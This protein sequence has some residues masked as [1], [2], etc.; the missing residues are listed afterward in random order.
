[1]KRE[2]H[3]SKSSLSW[4]ISW[5]LRLVRDACLTFAYESRRRFGRCFGRRSLYTPGRTVANPFIDASNGV[6]KHDKSVALRNVFAQAEFEKHL[7]NFEPNK[8]TVL[9]VTHE[10]SR[11]ESAI[12]V[13]RIGAALRQQY[14]LIVLTLQGGTLRNEIIAAGHLVLGPLSEEQRSPGFLTQLVA[15]I[16]RRTPVKFAIVNSIQSSIALSALWES[17][18][19]NV[20]LIHELAGETR[21][22]GQFRISALFSGERIFPSK[23]VRDAATA[24]TPDETSKPGLILPHNICVPHGNVVSATADVTERKQ[25]HSKPASFPQDELCFKSFI[26]R[27]DTVT[28]QCASKKEQEKVDRLVISKSN[29]FDVDFFRSPLGEVKQDDPVKSYVSAFSSGIKPRKATPGFHPA[30]Y[31]EHNDVDGRDPLAHYIDSGRPSGPWNFEVIRPGQTSHASNSLKVGLH[32]H[33]YYDEMISDIVNRLRRV[34]SPMDLLVS[35]TNPAAGEVAQACLSDY[36]QGRVD[37]RV[38]DN[39]GRNLGPLLSGFG[40]TILERYDIVGHIHTKKSVGIYS[41]EAFVQH[42][43]KFLYANLLADEHAMADTILQRMT[44]D[45]SIGL[46]FPDDPHIFGWA[47]NLPYALDLSRRMGI[48]KTMLP[49]MTFNFPVG[50]MFWAR[51]IALGPLFELGLSWD[52]YPAEPLPC[53]GSLLHAIERL[54]PCVA[55][56][57]GFRC[58]LTHVP[59][60]TR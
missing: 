46:V 37:V 50:T 8:E 31:Q 54:L 27:L 55:K 32:L 9:I 43:V 56:N 20:H 44:A 22:K 18:I 34:R 60:I 1:M 10:V 59:G 35:V 23:L 14:N 6:G 39:C 16:A 57:A 42:W 7:L 29:L 21:P 53:D 25:I 5:R 30:T 26:E 40:K 38:F 58:V 52:D 15:E 2:Y 24:E 48:Q 47:S 41:S 33:L 4:K 3:S 36:S 17:D 49:K 13:Q 11:S 12:L 51:T 19:A 28:R 45:D